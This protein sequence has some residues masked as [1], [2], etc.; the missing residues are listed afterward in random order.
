MA[1]DPDLASIIAKAVS[2][3]GFSLVEIEEICPE[4]GISRNPDSVRSL[5]SVVETQKQITGGRNGDSARDDFASIYRRT[6]PR[7]SDDTGLSRDD[8]IEV[9]FAHSLDRQTEIILAGSAGERVQS[10]AR[11]LCRAAALCGLFCTQKNDNPV[12]QG[13]GFSLSEVI[14]SPQPIRYTAIQHPG[15]IIAVSQDGLRELKS[16]YALQSAS[17]D[18]IIVAD[19]SLEI[20]E[21]AARVISHPFRKAGAKKAALTAVEYYVNLTKPFAITA[22]REA[23][24]LRV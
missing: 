5:K 1:T 15:A 7:G 9:K 13:S 16:G 21:T 22:L 19:D 12:T 20:P 8:D 10:T 2:N 18:T 14:L 3:T 6:F 17:A 4:H 23:A 11:I 24:G